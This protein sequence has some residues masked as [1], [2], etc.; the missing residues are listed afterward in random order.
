MEGYARFGPDVEWL[1]GDS[2]AA[3]DPY[4][5]VSSQHLGVSSNLYDVDIS[6]AELFYE[7]IERYFPII[8]DFTLVPDYCGIRPK[9]RSPLTP[10]GINMDF[11]IET[12][13]VHEVSGL[14]NL[15]GIESPG[16][17]ASLSIGE[18][19]ADNIVSH[20]V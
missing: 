1:I 5:F 6:R 4:R 13:E 16:L 3:D 19:V 9:L 15:F 11:S 14:V 20:I 7:A 12:S 10:K 8:R 17:T 18:F 2:S